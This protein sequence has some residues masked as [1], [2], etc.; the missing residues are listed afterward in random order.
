MV[1][2][3]C[4][5]E[6]NIPIETSINTS[7]NVNYISQKHIGELGTTYHSESNR[8]EIPDASYPTLGKVKDWP[9]HFPDLTLGGPWFRKSGATLDI[10]NS[11]LLLEDNFAIPFKEVNYI[12]TLSDN[13]SLHPAL[14]VSQLWYRCGAPILWRRIELKGKDLYPGQSLPNDYNYLAKDR[15]QLNKFIRIEC[16]KDLSQLK[17]FIKLDPIRVEIERVLISRESRVIN[18]RTRFHQTLGQHNSN[19]FMTVDSGADHPIIAIGRQAP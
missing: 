13:K 4:V 6:E 8:I 3:N 19:I 11:K 16:A 14:F 15:P 9:D 5:V 10:R 17:K 2:V 1:C 18:S 12:L 7:A